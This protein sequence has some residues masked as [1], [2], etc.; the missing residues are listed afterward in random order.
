MPTF[1]SLPL[2][3]RTAG[4][5]Q[6]GWKAGISDSAFPRVASVKPVPGIPSASRRFASVLC[7]SRAELRIPC[8]VSGWRAVLAPPCEEVSPLPQRPSLRSGLYCPGPS[9]LMRPHPPHSRAQHPFAA[10]RFIGAAFAV[11][12]RLG[13]PRVVLRFRWS[14]LLDMQPSTTAGSPSVAY[15]QF[16]HR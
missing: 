2:S 8:T 3:F 15:A 9:S 11:R 6:Y 5:P 13:D 10:G 12:V 1:P 16:L 14:F 7:A 4:F